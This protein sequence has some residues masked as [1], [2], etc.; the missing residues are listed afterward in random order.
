MSKNDIVWIKY[1]EN[2]HFHNVSYGTINTKKAINIQKV[3]CPLLGT[4]F[5]WQCVKHLMGAWSLKVL[6]IL[7]I[8]WYS[9]MKQ[10]QST[11][12]VTPVLIGESLNLSYSQHSGTICIVCVVEHSVV[13]A[14]CRIS[15]MLHL[16]VL[17][18]IQNLICTVHQVVPLWCG[19]KTKYH[20]HNGAY[21]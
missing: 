14:C 2:S 20:I 10:D 4:S 1:M 16:G 7:N 6:S 18:F 9:W 8:N 13:P 21:E 12:I 17:I 3:I 15:I 19:I 11:F 5:V